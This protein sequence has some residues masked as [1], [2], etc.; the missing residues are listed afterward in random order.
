MTGRLGELAVRFGCQLRGDPQAGVE[1][2]STL[3]AA[4][5][6]SIAFLAN[7]QYRKF[8]ATTRATAV[9]LDAPNTPHFPTALLLSQKPYALYPRV[10]A[11]PHPAPQAPPGPPGS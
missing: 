5:P 10:P 3:E 1:T 6:G 7:P 4:G 2:V 11:P 8:L 9:I